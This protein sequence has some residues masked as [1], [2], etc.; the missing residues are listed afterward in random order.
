MFGHKKVPK[1]LMIE[2]QE[3]N[4]LLY[5]TVFEAAGF[6]VDFKQKIT[7]EFL[8]EVAILAPDIISLDLMFEDDVTQNPFAGFE[9]L[10]LLQED[11]RTAHIP[12][13][14]L[15]A[16]FEEGKVVQ[17]RDLGAVDFIN[18]NGHEPRHLPKM[19]LEYLANPKHYLPLHPLFRSR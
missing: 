11:A 9:L 6:S 17:A 16:F 13:I 18:V 4:Y 19:F 8:E 12:V 2:D 7:D 3:V 1:I 15:T 14:I 5:R 10:S